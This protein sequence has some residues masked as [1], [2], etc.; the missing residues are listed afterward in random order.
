MQLCYIFHPADSAWALAC[1]GFVMLVSYRGGLQHDAFRRGR[2]DMRAMTRVGD[3]YPGQGNGANSLHLA[4][5]EINLPILIC[6][7]GNFYVLKR[8]QPVRVS[9]GGKAEA[10]LSALALQSDYCVSRDGLLGILWP[11]T[12]SE[13]A[14]QSL[15][16]LVYTLHKR[17]GD[18]I[19]GAAPV[20]HADGYY[21][22]N[23]EAGVGVDVACFDVLARMGDQQAGAGNQSAAVAAYDRALH[24]YRGDVC[25]GNDLHAVLERERLRARYLALLTH[26]ADYHFSEGNYAACLDYAQRLLDKDPCREDAHRLIM[27]CF[28]RRGE[29]A[30]ALR[31]Y[32]LCQDILRAEFDAVPEPATTA[33]FDTVRLYPDSV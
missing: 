24:W 33:L 19:G 29:R 4:T 6:L 16:S 21:L 31:Q 1:G 11:N 5:A 20:L 12:H 27:R 14:V 15:N 18:A 26:L 8:G 22:L 9:N 25:A 13:L 28:V 2:G 7:L 30:Q 32:R 3:D 17:L 23:V 10:L